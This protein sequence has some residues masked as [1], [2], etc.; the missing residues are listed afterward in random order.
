VLVGERQPIA[1]LMPPQSCT[2]A[3][4]AS[5]SSRPC[6]AAGAPSHI[7]IRAPQDTG[8]RR[9]EEAPATQAGHPHPVLSRSTS[10][11]AQALWAPRAALGNRVRNATAS[12]YVGLR[13]ASGAARW[14]RAAWRRLSAPDHTAATGFPQAVVAAVPWLAPNSP[15]SATPAWPLPA[16]PGKVRFWLPWGSPR[17]FP[18]PD[19]AIWKKGKRF[20]KSMA[21]R[22]GR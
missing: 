18:K 9:A 2:G 6:N 20:P 14:S 5:W 15:V 11:K 3:G 17:L 22:S 19:T 4:A 21:I 1:W 12:S 8:L 7:F 16:P 10:G 13:Y